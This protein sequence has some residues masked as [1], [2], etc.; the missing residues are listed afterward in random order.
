M[1]P[2][3][4]RPAGV[5]GLQGQASV[6]GV[7][8]SRA[9]QQLGT[10]RCRS[11]LLLR[12]LQELTGPRAPQLVRDAASQFRLGT[13]A[14]SPR[15]TVA[16]AYAGALVVMVGTQIAPS[17]SSTSRSRHVGSGART[18]RQP[19]SAWRMAVQSATKASATS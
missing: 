7:E 8:P 6:G 17:H 19:F 12:R 10:P 18:G 5:H 14:C 4:A 3:A 1:G 11:P 16:A 13:A 15:W 9:Q 2:L